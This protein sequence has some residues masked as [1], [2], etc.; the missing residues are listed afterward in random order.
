MVFLS[1]FN[2]TTAHLVLSG[3]QFEDDL[4]RLRVK[5]THNFVLSKNQSLKLFVKQQWQE[6]DVEFSNVNLSYQSYF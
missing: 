5:Y 6:N 2:D 3:K 4:Y 1:H